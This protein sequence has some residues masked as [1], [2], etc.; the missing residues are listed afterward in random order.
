MPGPGG[1]VESGSEDAAP[2]PV[3][4]TAGRGL[5]NRSAGNG[6]TGV[7]YVIAGG[8]LIKTAGFG[9][10]S[11]GEQ[12]YFRRGLDWAQ[13]CCVTQVFMSSMIAIH[14]T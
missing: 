6:V 1:L 9:G 10:V 3:P 5:V 2:P 4:V 7:G 11:D 13:S 12:D 14:V 8:F